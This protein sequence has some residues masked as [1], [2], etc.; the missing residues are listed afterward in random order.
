MSTL[1]VDTLVA[2]DG[3]SAVTLTKQS[4][5]KAWINLDGTGTISARDGFNNSS[6]TDNGTGDYRIS[7]N[8]SMSNSNYATPCSGGNTASGRYN[9]IAESDG[10]ATGS[11]DFFGFQTSTGGAL[12]NDEVSTCFHGDLA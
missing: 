6:V 5:A 7:I 12:D 2:A 8:N 1:K 11:A 4:A 9:I 3:S 10:K